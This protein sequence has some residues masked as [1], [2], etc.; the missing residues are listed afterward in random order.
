MEKKEL[1]NSTLIL[2]FGILSIVGC[3]CYG[4]L[5]VV[6]GIIAL[7]MSNRAMEIYS[8]NPEL[9][10][11]YQNV[12]TGRILAIIGLVLSALSV[13]SLIISLIFFGGLEGIYEIQEGI[14]REYGG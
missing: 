6:F 8:A 11:G 3:C 4:I 14:L 1:P 13:L 2:V 9:Y 5:G 12:K 7:I 10:T